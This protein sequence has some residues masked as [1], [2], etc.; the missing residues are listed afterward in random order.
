M[1]D[2]TGQVFDRSDKLAKMSVYIEQALSGEL[3][4]A[5]EFTKRAKGSANARRDA[6]PLSGQVFIEN[7]ASNIASVIELTG[8]DR[9][10]FL[11]DVTSTMAELGLSIATAHIST[12]GAQVADVFYVKD[13]FGMKITHET[14]MKQVREKLLQAIG[15]GA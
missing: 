6:L 10:G 2:A 7:N 14:R 4:I 1:Q 13:A 3:D 11:Y 15:G 12:Y 5:A 9:S 8:H